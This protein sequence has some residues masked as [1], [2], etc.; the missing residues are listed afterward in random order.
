LIRL[1]PDVCLG[2]MFEA[3]LVCH[4]YSRFFNKLCVVRLAGYDFELLH[5][6]LHEKE[7]NSQYREML[8]YFLLF[9]VIFRIVKKRIQFVVL[10]KAM[11]EGLLK[12]QVEPDHV[13]LIYNFIDSRFFRDIGCKT[14]NLT[15]LFC[16]RLVA[17]KGIDVLMKAFAIV[18]KNVPNARLILVGDGAQRSSI[19]KLIIDLNLSAHVEVKG[20]VPFHKVSEYLSSAHIF[21]LPSIYEGTPNVLLQA[22]ATG[23]P[24]VAT[25]VGGIPDLVNDDVDGLLVEPKDAVALA[26][27]IQLLLVNNE[28]A[29]R[30][31]HSAHKKALA[32]KTE[33]IVEKYLNLFNGLIKEK[34]K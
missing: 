32:F 30:F 14:E 5:P 13:H 4:W 1:K 15:V 26:K 8:L 9:P 20:A 24:I 2:V 6:Q 21:V 33:K 17:Q 16:G 23:L 31:R 22:M 3:A 34:S 27:A 28:L 11:F 18:V 25:K 19:E 7:H 12:L 29:E 10:N